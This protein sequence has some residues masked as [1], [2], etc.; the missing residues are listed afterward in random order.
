MTRPVVAI[1]TGSNDYQ[2][3][4][5]RS[6]LG[7]LE[8]HGI[9]LIAHTNDMLRREAVFSSLD[10][11]LRDVDPLGVIRSGALGPDDEQRLSV[12]L[13]SR[14]APVVNVGFDTPGV[15]AVYGDN[16]AGMRAL[17][18]HLLD[19]VGVRRPVLI[20]G[21]RHQPDSVVTPEMLN[22]TPVYGTG[23]WISTRSER[24][25]GISRFVNLSHRITGPPGTSPGR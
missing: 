3:R 15:T 13:A 20:R 12:L 10:R 25:W 9:P 6:T 7:P 17:M 14:R 24:R 5:L 22:T 4:L 8:R 2:L 19:E 1:V 11:L 21:I 18:T 16:T 23:P